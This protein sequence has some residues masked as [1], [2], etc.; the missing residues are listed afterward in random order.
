MEKLRP[1]LELNVD[2]NNGIIPLIGEVDDNMYARLVT[3]LTALSN[4]NLEYS[5][6]TILLNTR[7]GEVDQAFAIYDLLRTQEIPIRVVC[8]GPV[9]SAG[10][11]I[12]MA[13]DKRH[14]SSHSYLVFHYGQDANTCANDIAHSNYMNKRYNELFKKTKITSKIL[15]KWSS[16]NVY[17]TPE[18]ALELGIVTGV[19]YEKKGNEKSAS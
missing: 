2:I 4:A 13:G 1:L 17:Y 12:L 7:G 19:I 14:M 9:L 16:T 3:C 15:E 5:E 18:K 6:L 10:T 8:N 11:I